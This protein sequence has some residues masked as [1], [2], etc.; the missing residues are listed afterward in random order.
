[1]K[2][3]TTIAFGALMAL[4]SAVPLERRQDITITTTVDVIETV[5]LVVTVW[6][7]AGG[8]PAD[9]EQH[10]QV[11]Q[12]NK[13]NSAP[14]THTTP[15]Q[16]AVVATQTPPPVEPQE[17]PAES[18]DQA[19]QA[20]EQ[21]NKAQV[22]KNEAAQE[23]SIQ[24]Q[25]KTNKAQEQANNDKIAQ[26]QAA[27]N[28]VAPAVNTP[29]AAPVEVAPVTQDN[30]SPDQ[31]Q[32]TSGGS[33][34]LVG[35]ACSADNVTY[36]GGGMG[37]CGWSNDTMSEDF[38][39]LAYGVHPIYL[40]SISSL[41]VYKQLKAMIDNTICRND[42]SNIQWKFVLRSYSGY[43][44]PRQD[45]SW[46]FNGQMHGLCKFWARQSIRL[47]SEADKTI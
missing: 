27:S 6:L 22:A 26:N 39:A 13:P 2:L 12:P 43:C 37:A 18:Q 19:N 20:Q 14:V 28:Q 25:D 38:F 4:S 5:D 23:Q 16:D 24:A 15:A 21:T 11:V 46:N 29:A 36:F 47:I 44:V 45:Y 1:M 30:T 35:G 42:G 10:R 3:S 17:A 31:T 32:A 7:P 9:Q 40:S 34:H 41:R 33:C 8:H